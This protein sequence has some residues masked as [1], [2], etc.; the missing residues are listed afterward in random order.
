MKNHNR[1]FPTIGHFESVFKSGILNQKYRLSEK[2]P[3]GKLTI[4]LN[5]YAEMIRF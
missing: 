1:D 5:R 4:F 2:W 3:I